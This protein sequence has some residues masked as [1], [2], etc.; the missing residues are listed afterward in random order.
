MPFTDVAYL[1]E[2]SSICARGRRPS[3]RRPRVR[4][5]SASRG[6]P[7]A[8]C[9]TSTTSMRFASMSMTPRTTPPVSAGKAYCPRGDDRA[10]HRSG[11]EDL[12]LAR[13]AARCRGSFHAMSQNGSVFHQAPDRGVRGITVEGLRNCPAAIAE[14]ACAREAGIRFVTALQDPEYR[15]SPADFVRWSANSGEV[16]IAR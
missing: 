10:R 9:P 16:R 5:R 7:A 4:R 8:R 3:S 2:R 14:S 15:S 13:D 11:Q 12:P 1:V 6:Y